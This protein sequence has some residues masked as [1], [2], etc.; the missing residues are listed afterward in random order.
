MSQKFP[1]IPIDNPKL[2]TTPTLEPL[3][4][5]L[6]F[7]CKSM[8]DSNFKNETTIYNR[9]NNQLS[10][11]SLLGGHSSKN[12]RPQPQLHTQNKTYR[13]SVIAAL[14]PPP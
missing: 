5:Y 8:Q 3:I 11:F 12:A 6:L 9:N 13:K 1:K 4:S 7:F 14:P 10:P 2:P